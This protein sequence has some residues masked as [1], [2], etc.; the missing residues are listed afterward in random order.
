MTH[1]SDFKI[2]WW[3]LTHILKNIKVIG[4]INVCDR[5]ESMMWCHKRHTDKV[6]S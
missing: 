3:V 6:L 1:Y 4:D 5:K 2:H